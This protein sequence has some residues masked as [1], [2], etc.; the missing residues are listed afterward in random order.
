MNTLNRFLLISKVVFAL[1][2]IA[3][4]AAPLY[5]FQKSGGTT[6]DGAPFTGIYAFGDSLSDTGNFFRLTGQ[7]GAP[8]FEGRISNGVVWLEYL[9]QSMEL[10]PDSVVNYSYAG[11]TTGRENENDIPGFVEFPGLQD[12]LDFFEADLNGKKADKRALYIVWAGANDVFVSG[13]S[14]GTI[15]TGV[16]NTVIA[17]QRLYQSGARRILVLN[18]PDLGLTPFGRSVNPVGLSFFTSAYNAAL[19]SAL[20][21]M[22]AQGIETIRVDSAGVL[23]DI[24][25]S[26]SDFGF[27]NVQDAY[28]PSFFGADP[29]E[30]L[31]W[32]S[33]HPTTDGHRFIAEEAFSILRHRFRHTWGTPRGFFARRN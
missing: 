3:S 20:D 30:F 4:T 8:Y 19:N 27:S 25:A 23:R 17:V 33:V 22:A 26:P 32:D 24:V 7:P 12:E 14:E 31:F 6:G 5:A 1:A 15:A 9:A 28:L 18:M 11:A 29:S 16:G 21:Q 2:V 10:N 13:P